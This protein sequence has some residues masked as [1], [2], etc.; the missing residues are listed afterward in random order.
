M[1][2][3]THVWIY[4]LCLYMSIR[5]VFTYQ[6]YRVLNLCVHYLNNFDIIKHV[7][8]SCRT[9]IHMYNLRNI[10]K[11]MSN[12]LRYFYFFLNFIKFSWLFLS[13]FIL[14]IIFFW[15]YICYKCQYMTNMDKHEYILHGV[16]DMT[17]FKHVCRIFM[18][19]TC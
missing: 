6:M 9:R 16:L 13:F 3:P 12:T 5:D 17:C 15:I 14:F 18:I 10:Y 8:L 11:D 19:L 4:V 2:V 1:S 7:R